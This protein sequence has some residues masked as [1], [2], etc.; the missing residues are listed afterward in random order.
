MDITGTGSGELLSGS[1]YADV[2]D[3]A[4]GNDTVLGLGGNDR[5]HG[6]AGNDRL[7]GGAGNDLLDGGAGNDMLEGGNGE[8]VYVF[9]R[10]SGN[11]TIADRGAAGEIDTIQLGQGI[12]L[13]QLRWS[14]GDGDLT[15]RIA[16][17]SDRLTI[18]DWRS[19]RDGVEQLR[20]ADGQTFSLRAL[21]RTYDDDDDRVAMGHGP[22]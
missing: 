18:R 20:L 11:D 22:W 3:G 19:G 21:V 16:N 13:N 12:T 9:G 2:I 4:G 17:T 6:G 1:P 10:G 5:L 7:H 8:D 15:L 14:T